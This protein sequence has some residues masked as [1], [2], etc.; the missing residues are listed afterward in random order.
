MRAAPRWEMS[1]AT[2]AAGQETTLQI[3]DREDGPDG[4]T[5]C[6]LLGSLRR[7]VADGEFVRL[8]DDQDIANAA[9]IMLL[10]R[11]RSTMSDLVEWASR[12]GGWDAS[13][14]RSAET[15]LLMPGKARAAVAAAN[16]GARP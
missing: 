4:R 9:M 13:C 1:P 16:A 5:V 11:L 6:I 15:L 8:L 2:A 14:W 3:I 7:R 10:P 12:T